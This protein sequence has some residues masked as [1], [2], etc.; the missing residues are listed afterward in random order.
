MKKFL[1]IVAV[2]AVMTACN[3]S[4]EKTVSTDTTKIETPVMDAK[5]ATDTTTKMMADTTTKMMDTSKMK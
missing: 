5:M 4:S 1:A 2:A 3:N